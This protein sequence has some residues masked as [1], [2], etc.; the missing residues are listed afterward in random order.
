MGRWEWAKIQGI[1]WRLEKFL[2]NWDLGPSSEKGSSRKHTENRV[3]RWRK[4]FWGN[5]AFSRWFTKRFVSGEFELGLFWGCGWESTWSH[6]GGGDHLVL[7]GGI[8]GN[9]PV[10]VNGVTYGWG[11][12]L[13]ADSRTRRLVSREAVSNPKLNPWVLL[14]RGTVAAD[15]G[16]KS[17]VLW[18]W[19]KSGRLL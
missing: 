4:L 3:T 12:L 5:S 6:W 17:W 11:V 16:H 10:N 19:V 1:E 8:S 13:K 14:N 2:G 18:L 7:F 9:S 15:K